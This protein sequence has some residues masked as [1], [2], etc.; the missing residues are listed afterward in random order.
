MSETTVLQ[1]KD[2]SETLGPPKKKK[3]KK[4]KKG[5]EEDS[6]VAP[7]TANS[8]YMSDV[9]AMLLPFLKSSSKEK[10]SAL[11]K[12]MK[13]LEAE[14]LSSSKPSAK[15]NTNGITNFTIYYTCKQG[16]MSNH[17]LEGTYTY[18]FIE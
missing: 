2:T 3:K 5:D 4:K 17:L 18:C 6:N 16:H 13:D 9:R 11:D 7:P 15:V 1:D 10:I 12:M 8:T 14:L